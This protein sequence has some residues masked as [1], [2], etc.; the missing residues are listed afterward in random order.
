MN[1]MLH[2]AT[3]S[4]FII[5]EVDIVQQVLKRSFTNWPHTSPSSTQMIA[6]GFF[7]CNVSDRVICAYCNLICHQWT[8]ATDDPCEVH[9]TLSPKCAYVKSNL[10]HREAAS[11]SVVNKNMMGIISRNF[12]KSLNYLDLSH[13]N[14]SISQSLL[15]RNISLSILRRCWKDQLQIKR[16]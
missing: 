8:S 4:S 9:K 1:I 12:S 13:C 16:Q 6:A 7:S 3:M 15:S 11:I 5:D 10:I 2:E 14:E